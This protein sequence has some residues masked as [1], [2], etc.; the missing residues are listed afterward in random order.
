MM[1]QILEGERHNLLQRW[2]CTLCERRVMLRSM[3]RSTLAN[4][5]FGYGLPVGPEF[6]GPGAERVGISAV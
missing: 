5:Y 2:Q 6:L 3:T 1:P 4:W